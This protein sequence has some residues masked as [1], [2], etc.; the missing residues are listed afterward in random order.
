MISLRKYK[1]EDIASFPHDLKFTDVPMYQLFPVRL[2]RGV[3]NYI[4]EEPLGAPAEQ[5]PSLRPSLERGDQQQQQPQGRTAGSS[6]GRLPPG[7]RRGSSLPFIG[8]QAG[9]PCAKGGPERAEGGRAYLAVEGS[10]ALLAAGHWAPPCLPLLKGA[11]PAHDRWPTY[12]AGAS[13]SS[14]LRPAERLAWP[15]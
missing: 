9:R 3:K 4:L 8:R 1:P 7:P 6:R 12:S 10:W 11:A 14:E 13:G 15:R 2:Q 5:P